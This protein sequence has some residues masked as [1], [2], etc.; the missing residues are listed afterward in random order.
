[1]LRLVVGAAV[2]L[3][4]CRLVGVL[5]QV[6]VRDV[7]MLAVHGAAQ[8][9][10]VAFRLIG[11]GSVEAV[12]EAVVDA[13]GV[14]GELDAIPMRGLVC[15]DHGAERHAGADDGGAL[16]LATNHEGQR[17]A[18]AL[19]QHYDNAAVT[20]LVCGQAAVLA[21]LLPVL[22]ANMTAE[23]RAVDLHHAVEVHGVIARR[24][25]LAQLVRQDEGRLV[26]A[27]QVARELERRNA[28][29][30]VDE[31]ADGGEQIDKRHLARGEDGSRRGRELLAA[32]A[33]L[34]LAAR[35]DLVGIGADA[36]RAEGFP[37]ILRK[38]D[39]RERAKRLAIGHAVDVLELE[40]PGGGGKEEVLGHCHHIRWCYP[41]YMRTCTIKV[42]GLY[43]QNR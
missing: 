15:V 40:G 10:E 13:A 33:A 21:V 23:I 4:P 37:A 18:R 28:L 31:D 38:A 5:V 1:M 16:S 11:A 3:A 39:C 34:P 41:S 20:V 24:H 9:G 22:R 2:V 42:N 19:A 32:G 43:H 25:R 8:A 26:L 17:A 27:G 12:G 30:R 6:L 7:V 35:G 29:G 14:V 36:I